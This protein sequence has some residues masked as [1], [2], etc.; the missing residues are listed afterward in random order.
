MSNNL[1]NLEYDLTKNL[2]PKD[3][4]LN[5]YKEALEYYLNIQKGGLC[6]YSD[7]TEEGYLGLCLIIPVLLWNLNSYLDN[8]LN[9]GDGNTYIWN[10]S[11]TKIAFP[12]IVLWVK[13]I[14]DTVEFPDKLILRIKAMKDCIEK[15]SSE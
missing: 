12:E 14:E 9:I 5:V 13:D 6:K 1:K 8:N 11:D 7:N 3:V 15:L 2:P 10:Y 4:R